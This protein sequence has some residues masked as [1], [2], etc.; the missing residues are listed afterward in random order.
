MDYSYYFGLF[1]SLDLSF[2]QYLFLCT[3]II[4]LTFGYVAFISFKI[5]SNYQRLVSLLVYIFSWFILGGLLSGFIMSCLAGILYVL[6][7]EFSGDY[8]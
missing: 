4:F 5:A 6:V 3:F 7:R 1:P 8:S 2:P